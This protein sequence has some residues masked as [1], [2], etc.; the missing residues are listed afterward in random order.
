MKL[1][2]I[3][4]CL[5]GLCLALTSLSTAASE[6]D[7]YLQEKKIIDAQ[8]KIIDEKALNE[9]LAVLS[10]EDSRTLPMQV[11]NNTSIEQLQLLHDRTLLK[12]RIT[13]PDFNQFEQSSSSEDIQKIIWDN[14][15]KNCDLLFEHQYQ[16]ANPYQIQLK[17]LSETNL[18]NVD[19]SQQDC[20][21]N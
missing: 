15:L 8:F 17:L 13:T 3:Y 19:I 18:Y 7:Q 21:F 20:K 2:T 11:D 6:F 10:A 4:S 1:K 5:M 12:G 14:V 9:L 16:R